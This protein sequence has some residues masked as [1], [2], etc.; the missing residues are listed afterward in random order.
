MFTYATL[1]SPLHVVPLVQF[2]S[3]SV[4][5]V[6]GEVIAYIQRLNAF[7]YYQGPSPPS[8][9][10]AQTSESARFPP[11]YTTFTTQNLNTMAAGRGY[12]TFHGFDT[13]PPPPGFA[14]SQPGSVL[15]YPILG[16]PQQPQGFGWSAQP[17]FPPP[18]MPS[19]SNAVPCSQPVMAHLT[20]HPAGD[21]GFPGV[22][23]VLAI[24][25]ELLVYRL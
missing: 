20:M 12:N 10:L 2:H 13:G 24:S 23:Y 7:A 6:D 19:Y 21:G 25:S 17:V 15:P 14:P 8:T 4:Y 5:S 22:Q 3:I 18:V 11:T 9:S 1:T 16:W